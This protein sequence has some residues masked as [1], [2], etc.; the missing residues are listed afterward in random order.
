MARQGTRSRLRCSGLQ[1]EA[2]Q[3]SFLK[4]RC[5]ET[6]H[7]FRTWL[8]L[9]RAGS[10]THKSWDSKGWSIKAHKPQESQDFKKKSN[11][12]NKEPS[13][14]SLQR[15]FSNEPWG[16]CSHPKWGNVELSMGG[17][18]PSGRIFYISDFTH[19]KS[20]LGGD[21]PTEVVSLLPFFMSQP[22]GDLRTSSN[23]RL[24]VSLLG[25]WMVDIVMHVLIWVK[26]T[27]A[28]H[29]G[30]LARRPSYSISYIYI[31][32][33]NKFF[34]LNWGT[35]PPKKR[36]LSTDVVYYKE[37][38]ASS[39]CSFKTTKLPWALNHFRGSIKC[40]FSIA[41][42]SLISSPIST[43]QCFLVWD[44]LRRVSSFYAGAWWRTCWKCWTPS[45]HN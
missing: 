6:C 28:R 35:P 32:Y 26:Q 9:Q 15:V 23:M 8:R 18:N 14:G 36:S 40:H 41:Y 45:L 11:E 34:G 24:L 10:P 1:T 25:Y 44:I 37:S 39:T 13:S 29:P 27:F 19:L 12:E 2:S 17:D 43:T 21:K 3:S 22:E 16:L 5:P 4:R 42:Q 30:P 38:T 7:F 33:P 20:I 31:K